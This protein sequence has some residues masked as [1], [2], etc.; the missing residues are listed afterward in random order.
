MS[1]SSWP[2]ASYKLSNT[3]Q[4]SHHFSSPGDI[5]PSPKLS[6]PPFPLPVN[7]NRHWPVFFFSFLFFPLLEY[8]FSFLRLPS[9][10]LVSKL[11]QTVGAFPRGREEE[12]EEEG[13]G[14]W[15]LLV[16]WRRFKHSH[17][18]PS[19]TSSRRRTSANRGNNFLVTSS[20]HCTPF[21]SFFLACLFRH[22]SLQVPP[23]AP[24]LPLLFEPLA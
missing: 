4:T 8:P 1:L 23:L 2:I 24:V 16:I 19:E 18:P 9:T 10:A 13:D 3:G 5:V 15:S 11:N 7:R 20:E 14:G 12:A 17:P 22:H 6:L 21:F